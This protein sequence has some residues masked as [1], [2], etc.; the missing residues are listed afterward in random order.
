MA[1]RLVSGTRVLMKDN[2]PNLFVVGAPKCGTTSLHAYLR[3]HP[4]IFMSDPKE[5]NFFAYSNGNPYGWRKEHPFWDEEAYIKL[6][7]SAGSAKIRG[8][9]SG[10]YSLM[11]HVASSIYAHN[12]QAKIVAILR[13][14]VERAWSMY[15]FWHQF[16][17][18][19]R[20]L[21][22]RD[23]R[24]RFLKD[25]LATEHEKRQPRQVKWLRGAGMYWNNLQHFYDVF[26]EQQ[27]YLL[28][29]DE[30]AN[31]PHRTLASL[32]Q[33]L[34]VDAFSFDTSR[35]EN[36]TA[37]PR[38]RCMYNFVNLA[39]DHPIRRRIKNSFASRLPLAA[40]KRTVN[41]LLLAIS[42]KPELPRPLYNELLGYYLDDL[43]RLT[44]QTGFSARN[45]L[46]PR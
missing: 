35:R 4:Q 44:D 40:L 45:W 11:P 21:H 24:E 43:Q 33:F 41:Q 36:V 7:E 16:D 28:N 14:P 34:G 46:I 12:P 25:D 2:L 18:S 17:A 5:P 6:F 38:F 9:S 26:P 8:E 27:I 30:F 31:R 37:A 3:Q 42:P 20:S 13:N 10:C 32:C 1:S 29:Y 39:I 22:L 19:V 15:Q 23:F